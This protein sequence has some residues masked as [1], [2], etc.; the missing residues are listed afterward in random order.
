MPD[1]IF[2]A[3]AHDGLGGHEANEPR[4]WEHFRSL[5]HLH[6]L[7]R[8]QEQSTACLGLI[9]HKRIDFISRLISIKLTP[10]AGHGSEDKLTQQKFLHSLARDLIGSII[11]IIIIIII[12]VI[13]MSCPHLHSAEFVG[14]SHWLS[15]VVVIVFVSR[16]IK[17]ANA[18]LK[19]N[20]INI[21]IN[22]SL[23]LLGQQEPAPSL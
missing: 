3:F 7:T 18:N 5:R 20:A 11:I 2:E 1:T 12:I 13:V 16:R 6:R 9:V 15:I 17:M 10:H 23:L 14:V 19:W 21:R 8:A 4:P 22:K